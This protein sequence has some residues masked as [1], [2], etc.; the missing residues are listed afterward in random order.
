MLR[1]FIF[2][3]LL[4]GISLGSQATAADS[5]N[6][7]ADDV[8]VESGTNVLVARGNVQI[9][10][11]GAVLTAEELR[12]DGENEQIN[13]VGPIR[14]TAPDGTVVTADFAELSA[15]LRQGLVKGA[16]LL[17]GAQ[18]QIA[19]KELSRDGDRFSTLENAVTSTCIVCD[20]NQTP[21][22]EI[23]A[24]K[25]THDAQKKRLYFEDAEFRLF[26][27]PV[28]Y[29]PYISLPDPTVKRASGFLL[30]NFRSSSIYGLGFEVPYYWAISD[31]SDA[32]ISYFWTTSDADLLDA[33][34]RLRFLGGGL[35]L[36]ATTATFGDSGIFRRGKL[37]ALATVPLPLDFVLEA[38][39]QRVSDNAFLREYDISNTDRLESIVTASRIQ[40]DSAIIADFVIFQS[41]RDI[42]STEPVTAILPEIRYDRFWDAE[43]GTFNVAANG[44]GLLRDNGRDVL[45]FGATGTWNRLFRTTNG[46]FFETG[47]GAGADY[48]LVAND[49]TYPEPLEKLA[50]SVSALWRWPL[51]RPFGDGT[52]IFEPIVQLVY[53]DVYAPN[54]M[55]P[56]EDSLQVE[57]NE[58]NLF[59]ENRF[60]GLDANETGGRLNVGGNLE[61]PLWGGWTFGASGGMVLR[62]EPT[63]VFDEGTG[64]SETASDLVAAV[65]FGDGDFLQSDTRVLFNSSL[66]FSRAE[67]DIQISYGRV[68][69][70]SALVYLAPDLNAG[71][72]SARSEGQLNVGYE[73]SDNWHVDAGWQRNF[74]EGRN[75][76][77][78]AAL[79]YRNECIEIGLS[80]SRNFTTS[81]NVP[82]TT[83]VSLIFQLAGFGQVSGN[84]RLNEICMDLR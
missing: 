56:N 53:S 55:P 30:P 19:A 81:N 35:D 79:V 24:K 23:R 8:Y 5:V 9:F 33:E 39:I 11:D 65:S 49:A 1:R 64:L 44:L 59:T 7:I 71:A 70:D 17:L 21:A 82:E 83:N 60:P 45:R 75:I 31:H 2:L 27:V 76:S 13:A 41:L 58:T 43:F 50:G 42:D 47:A 69:V 38:D 52:F 40:N 67:T 15:D 22:W 34:Y 63:A 78:E 28:T 12:Y 37:A 20:E 57:F 66:E 32:T 72:T 62:A 68:Q 73:L 16:R 3:V 26:G 29:I 10:Y 77:A 84:S 46:M 74:S 36:M 25:V 4:T 14:I 61:F 80:L 6:L 48:Y 18:L 51:A 54:G